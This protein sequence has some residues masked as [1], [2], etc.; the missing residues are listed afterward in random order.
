MRLRDSIH[1]VDAEGVE[2]RRREDYM[3]ESM[4]LKGLI[5][6]GT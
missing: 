3:D 2:N 4:T 1:R 5:I 6:Y